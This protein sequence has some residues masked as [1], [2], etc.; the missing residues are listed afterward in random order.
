[1]EIENVR[2]VNSDYTVQALIDHKLIEVVGRKDAIGKPLLFGTTDEFLKR[3]GLEDLSQLPDN[4]ALMERIKTIYDETDQSNE[5]FNNFEIK[6]VEENFEKRDMQ[7]E[8]LSLSDIDSKIKKAMEN[9]NFKI[10]DKEDIP[11]FL[12]GENVDVVS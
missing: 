8:E 9:I 4:D 2:G 10:P 12:K 6:P 7:R 3:F 11:E 5:L 1:M